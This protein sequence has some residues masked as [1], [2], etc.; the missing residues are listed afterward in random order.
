LRGGD[1]DEDIVEIK[2][3]RDSSITSKP[4][5]EEDNDADDLE[6]VT[7]YGYGFW[8][9][10]L[11]LYPVRLIPGKN[12]AWYFVSRLTMNLPA[13]DGALG[14]RMLAIW[15]GQGYYHFTTCNAA[16]NQWNVVHNVPYGDIE[17]LWTY[18]YYSHSVV[19]KKSVGFVKYGAKG[20][21]I[22]FQMGV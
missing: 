10:F 7:E 6:N 13:K 16:N 19:F 3:I 9:R 22:R 1:D 4:A 2:D 15:Q 8:M 17:G 20:D 18:I 12:A 21:V 11:T 14:D 5:A